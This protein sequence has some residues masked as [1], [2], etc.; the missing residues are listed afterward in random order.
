[1]TE[2]ISMKHL[3]ALI[4]ILTLFSIIFAQTPPVVYNAIT[5]RIAYG[6]S[7]IPNFSDPTHQRNF[8]WTEPVPFN[9]TSIR[10]TDPTFDP[11]SLGQNF[12]PPDTAEVRSINID[13]TRFY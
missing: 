1:M 9:S 8:I 4:S 12:L 10:I 2:P 7:S 11:D 5:D 3:V 6:E 13:S